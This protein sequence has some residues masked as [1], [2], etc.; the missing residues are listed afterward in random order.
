[1]SYF[2]DHAPYL[3]NPVVSEQ[4]KNKQTEEKKMY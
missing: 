4:V 1:M 2:T 3:I